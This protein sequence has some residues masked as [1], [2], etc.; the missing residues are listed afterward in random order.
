MAPPGSEKYAGGS[1]TYK[2]IGWAHDEVALSWDDIFRYIGP[3]FADGKTRSE[4][5]EEMAIMYSLCD[6]HKT[7]PK[8]VSKQIYAN[9]LRNEYSLP[10][11]CVRPN[12]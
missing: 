1:D 8:P 4:A 12:F 5:L 6:R 3:N 9:I 7:V 10:I 2:V 11:L